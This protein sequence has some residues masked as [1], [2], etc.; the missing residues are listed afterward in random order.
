MGLSLLDLHFVL[1]MGLLALARAWAPARYTLYVGLA[2]SMLLVGLASIS[3]LGSIGLISLLYLYPAHRLWV[4]LRRGGSTRRARWFLGLSMAGLILMLVVFKI[5]RHFEAAFLGGLWLH[6]QILTWVG[7]SYFIFRAI[8]FLHIQS[9]T[10]IDEQR[11]WP[12]LYF[13]LFPPTLTSGPIQKFQD[14]REQAASPARLDGAS[15][16]EACYRITRGYFRKA[17]LA[18][19]C[20]AIVKAMLSAETPRVYS[21]ALVIIFLYLYFYFDFAGYS[22]VAIGFGSL[23]GVRVPENFRKPFLATSVTEFWRNW[24]ITLVDWFRDNVYIPMGGMRAGRKE[25]AGL[26]FLIMVLCGFWHGLTLGFLAWGCWHGMLLATES[27]TGSRPMPPSRRQG[28][29]YWGRVGWT[30]AR[31]ALGTL[32]FLPDPQSVSSV[33][34]GFARW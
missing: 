27:L 33:L 34:S 17:V 12:L 32:F 15:V 16:G 28:W 22:D 10:P 8:Q 25:A 6:N 1:L 5:H 26:A 18:F 9:V 31:V 19:G 11:P 21:S 14:F 29:F 7:F 2:G 3:T 20:D 23:M 4:R 30:N 24:H 13:M